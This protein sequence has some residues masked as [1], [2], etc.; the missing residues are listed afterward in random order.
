MTTE[1]KRRPKIRNGVHHSAPSEGNGTTG[2]IG[3]FRWSRL[4][5][6]CVL[7]EPALVVLVLFG[8]PCEPYQRANNAK[9]EACKGPNERSSDVLQ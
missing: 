4:A 2:S 8:L 6:F 3:A 9:D 7:S 5:F 1:G